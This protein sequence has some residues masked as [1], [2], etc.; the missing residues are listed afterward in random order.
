MTHEGTNGIIYAQPT[1]WFFVQAFAG[2]QF[3]FPFEYGPS[4]VSEAPAAGKLIHTE[5]AYVAPLGTV[6]VERSGRWCYAGRIDVKKSSETP[7]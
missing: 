3:A 2:A 7:T 6:L 1:G 5:N 4:N